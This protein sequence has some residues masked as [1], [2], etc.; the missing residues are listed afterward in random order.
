MYVEFSDPFEAVYAHGGSGLVGTIEVAILD[1]DGNTVVGP[2]T[3]NITEEEVDGNPIGIYTWNAP[4]APAVAGQYFIVWSPDG[5]WD[6]ETTSTP[7]ELY[8]V[9][10]ADAGTLPP[11]SPPVDTSLITGPCTAWTTSLAV[12]ACAGIDNTNALDDPI[13]AASEILY[14]LSGH[15]FPGVCERTVRPCQTD[16]RWCGVQILSRG[17]IIN[18]GGTG[19]NGYDCGCNPL[20]EVPL[21]GT[22]VHEITEVKIDGVVIDP[23]EYRLDNNK[24]LV[25]MNGGRWPACQRLDLDDTEDG[26]WSVTYTHGRPIPMAGQ[27]A[28]RDLA[29]EIYKSCIDDEGECELPEGVTRVT[30]QGLTYELPA[31][32]SW[33]RDFNGIWRTGLRMVDA[34]L[35]AFNPKGLQR[36]PVLYV[37][38]AQKQ[39][40]RVGS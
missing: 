19:W 11:L 33:G 40:R 29:Y 9:E 26:T 32:V 24:W 13:Y 15:R 23:S 6:P 18:W 37:P 14:E 20:S 36:R 39:A 10:D 1:G 17:H 5:L 16:N 12:A 31:F 22:P 8:V 27:M 30:R 4:A 3:T 34:F 35:N 28:A 38:G 21:A 25:A 2:A 7:D